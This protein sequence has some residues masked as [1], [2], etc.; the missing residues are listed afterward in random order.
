MVCCYDEAEILNKYRSDLESKSFEENVNTV[1]DLLKTLY[2][3]NNEELIGLLS[4]DAYNFFINSKNDVEAVGNYDKHL[5]MSVHND[6]EN[7]SFKAGYLTERHYDD[8]EFFGSFHV[9]YI[10]DENTKA[11][12]DFVFEDSETLRILNT[13]S[14]SY[15]EIIGDRAEEKSMRTV[16]T[17][18]ICEKDGR[19][20][21][22]LEGPGVSICCFLEDF[23]NIIGALKGVSSNKDLLF[24]ELTKPEYF[25]DYKVSVRNRK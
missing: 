18:V 21:Y 6:T 2:S 17:E 1:R 7:G 23:V 11:D 8:G 13:I 16:Y 24:P 10:L 20:A 9:S 19:L 3:G 22:K 14:Q 5:D 15:T 25:K 12:R 4:Y